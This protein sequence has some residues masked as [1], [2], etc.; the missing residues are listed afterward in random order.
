MTRLYE[1]V[2]IL[3][4][5]LPEHGLD[6]ALNKYQTLLQEQNAESITVQHRGK[7]RLAYE[8][9]KN[10]EGIYIQMNYLGNPGT[11]EILEKYL[12]LDESVIRYLTTK[13]TTEAMTAVEISLPPEPPAP[14]KIGDRS[15]RPKPEVLVDKTIDKP[16]VV[17]AEVA[18]VVEADQIEDVVSAI[19]E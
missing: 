2:Y 3:K 5:D 18:E 16:V 7:R 10:R 4:T 19:E 9:N 17:D 11:V 6:E 15:D 8:I 1:T 13:T 12:R 14:P